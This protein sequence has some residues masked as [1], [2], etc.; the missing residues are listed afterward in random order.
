[1]GDLMGALKADGKDIGE[2]PVSAV[3]SGYGR[4]A[5]SIVVAN[6]PISRSVP[7]R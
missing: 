6:V 3:N 1:M 2:S 4:L 5:G 7:P